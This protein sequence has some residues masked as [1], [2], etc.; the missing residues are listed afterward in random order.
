MV[1]RI[2]DKNSEE[3]AKIIIRNEDNK[4]KLTIEKKAFNLHDKH[5]SFFNTNTKEVRA[6]AIFIAEIDKIWT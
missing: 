6:S 1:E 5:D 3:I 4:P 2:K